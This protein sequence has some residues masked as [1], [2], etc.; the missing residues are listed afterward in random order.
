[1]LLTLRSSIINPGRS[2]NSIRITLL[3]RL[4]IFCDKSPVCRTHLTILVYSLNSLPVQALTVV[5]VIIN[6]SLLLLVCILIFYFYNFWNH[7]CLV[8]LSPLISLNMLSWTVQESC[9]SSPNLCYGTPPQSTILSHTLLY[10]NL[11]KVVFI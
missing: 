3:Y 6:V 1:M 9:G 5:Q 4:N 7:M 11:H 8:S 2:T 10:L